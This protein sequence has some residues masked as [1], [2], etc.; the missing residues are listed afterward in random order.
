MVR[1]KSL[2]V[3]VASVVSVAG[4]VVLA[5]CPKD[6]KGSAAEI[7]VKPDASA[8]N[9]V[10]IE[11]TVPVGKKVACDKILDAAATATALGEAEVTIS[12][13][14][15]AGEKEATSICSVRK[16]GK[17]LTDKEQ[18]KL[19]EKEG[20][21]IGVQPGDE[22][23]Q[24]RAYCSY[25]YDIAETKKKAEAMGQACNTDIG[26]LSCVQ[27][28]QAGADYRYVVTVLDPDSKCRYVISP[29][30]ITTQEPM[31]ACAKTFVEQIT[32]EKLQA[33]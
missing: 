4:V 17:A 27:Q 6:E 12:D 14:T 2:V 11:T 5:G 1:I 15:M 7:R 32:K 19:M 3:L 26:D 25:P 33:P 22:I 29:T 24:L 18:A 10:R 13:S 9:I 16:T 23:C 30:T 20:F 21:K 28:V 31:L 8:A